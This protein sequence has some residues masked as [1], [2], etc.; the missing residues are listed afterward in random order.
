MSARRG[1]STGGSD[2]LSTSGRASGFTLVELLVVIAIIGLLISILIPSLSG[3]RN[4]AKATVTRALTGAVDAGQAA[5]QNEQSLGGTFVPSATDSQLS[6]SHIY[7]QVADPPTDA[8]TLVDNIPGIS[9]LVYGLMGVD[10][11]GAVGFRDVDGNGYWYDD[12]GNN[13]DTT[14]PSSSGLHALYPRTHALKGD[15]V[16]PRYRGLVG[17]TMT[18]HV[19]RISDLIMEGTIVNPTALNLTSVQQRQLVLVDAWQR[20]MLYYR[21]RTSAK[22][23]VTDITATSP[24]PGV[25]DQRDNQ[26]I[27][28]ISGSG[29]STPLP[30]MDFGA[31]VQPTG[32]RHMLTKYCPAAKLYVDC[33]VDEDDANF[34]GTFTRFIWDPRGKPLN[35]PYRP[36]SYLLISAGVDA[37]FG[38]SDDVTNY[39]AE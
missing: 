32:E 25:Y 20:P 7:G 6:P 33:C 12:L 36:D 19:R 24:T 14:S 30:G 22:I 39:A 3:A 1:H 29:V 17:D 16:H 34:R 4:Q 28:G 38:T 37:L 23:M 2:P 13:Y 26:L 11:R 18:D 31:G 15:P 8:P 9:L 21:A 27:T 5:F 35:V 10:R